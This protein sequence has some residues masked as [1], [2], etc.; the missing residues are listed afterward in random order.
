[1]NIHFD[2]IE[3]VWEKNYI[4]PAV[5][6]MRKIIVFAI[7][8]RHIY[9]YPCQR[10]YSWFSKKKIW[11]FSKN[12]FRH[13]KKIFFWSYKNKMLFTFIYVRNKCVLG[14]YMSFWKKN[15]VFTFVFEKIPDLHENWKN[16]YVEDKEIYRKENLQ[17]KKFCF[18]DF[19]LEKRYGSYLPFREE[20]KWKQWVL[21]KRSTFYISK[22]RFFPINCH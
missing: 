17:K 9:V 16:A 5:T 4:V 12:F 11:K 2:L 6:D 22:F 10:W 8:V 18:L 21:S 15:R 19:F 3:K 14:S 13:Q 7:I 1:M 20:T